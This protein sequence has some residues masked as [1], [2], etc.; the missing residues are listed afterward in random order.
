MSAHILSTIK[1][2]QPSEVQVQVGRPGSRLRHLFVG[3]CTPCQWHAAAASFHY[4]LRTHVKPYFRQVAF[5][6]V[7]KRLAARYFCI[8]GLKRRNVLAPLKQRHLGCGVS[9]V[10]CACIGCASPPCVCFCHSSPPQ[11]IR[12]LGGDVATVAHIKR[13]VVGNAC[14]HALRLL[15]CSSDR[16]TISR[17]RENLRVCVDSLSYCYP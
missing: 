13:A 5:D 2:G 6:S 11:P 15:P 9:G 3:I 17:S 7:H 8:V 1:I 12:S 14:P 16:P 10:F 4:T